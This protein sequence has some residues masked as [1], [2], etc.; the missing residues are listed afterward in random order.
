M[1]PYPKGLSCFATC[2]RRAACTVAIN[3]G[4]PVQSADKSGAAATFYARLSKART[5]PPLICPHVLSPCRFRATANCLSAAC[6][7]GGCILRRYGQEPPKTFPAGKAF[8]KKLPL[9]GGAGFICSVTFS[10]RQNPYETAFSRCL[11]FNQ[12]RLKS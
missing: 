11:D 6:R 7:C 8:P 1:P 5:G 9:Q 2:A 12:L 3:H 4:R 10:A